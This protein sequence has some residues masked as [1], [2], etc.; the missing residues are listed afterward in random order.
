M[1]FCLQ[2]RLQTQVQFLNRKAFIYLSE[3]CY[4][5]L[6]KPLKYLVLEIIFFLLTHMYQKLG[7][8]YVPL[9]IM[10]HLSSL[11]IIMK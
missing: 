3:I 7:F 11:A 8:Q 9:C 6:E 4:F 5:M 1:F 10:D 2:T